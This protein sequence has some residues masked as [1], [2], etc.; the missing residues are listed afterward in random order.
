MIKNIIKSV[1]IL[2]QLLNINGFMISEG[3]NIFQFNKNIRKSSNIL[4]LNQDFVVIFQDGIY[5][6]YHLLF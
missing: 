1:V 3:G 5:Y 2:T 6:I 4:N